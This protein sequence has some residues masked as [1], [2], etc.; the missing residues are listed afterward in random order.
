MRL[1]CVHCGAKLRESGS[2]VRTEWVPLHP[3]RALAGFRLSQLF[4]PAMSPRELFARWRQCERS[5]VRMENF[6]ISILGK[7]FAGDRQPIGADVVRA[8]SGDWL[9]GLR[10][11]LSRLPEDAHPAILG[12]ADIGDTIHAGIAV[13]WES[14]AHVVELHALAERK[15]GGVVE[16][17]WDQL[18]RLFAGCDYFVID[19]APERSQARKLLRSDGLTGAMCFFPSNCQEL[20]VGRAEEEIDTDLRVVKQDRTTAIDDMAD[21]LKHGDL[22]LP[23]PRVELMGEVARHLSKLVKDPNPTT[24]RREYKRGVENHWG[25]MLTYMLLAVQTAPLFGLG[26]GAPLGDPATW[27]VRT[28]SRKESW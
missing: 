7:P 26:P 10:L 22:L 16:S 23:S 24:G 28:R 3:G 6:V 21:A 15:S 18:A 11:F 20:S 9:L 5:R 25:L 2:E 19:A 13:L 4:G 27:T 17:P 14:K 1:A 12:A 8:A